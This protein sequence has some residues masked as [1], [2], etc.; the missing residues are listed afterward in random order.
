MEEQLKE[1]QNEFPN[2]WIGFN[3]T[4]GKKSIYIIPI[5]WC[6]SLFIVKI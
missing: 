5:S 2:A 3:A 6:N 4:T 1:V